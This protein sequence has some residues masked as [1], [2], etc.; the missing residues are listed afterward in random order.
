MYR[1]QRRSKHILLDSTLTG[2]NDQLERL[3]IYYGIKPGKNCSFF[4][5]RINFI[6][7]KNLY[8]YK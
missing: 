5:V 7:F 6:R 4:F 2:D 3:I 8:Y 1:Q